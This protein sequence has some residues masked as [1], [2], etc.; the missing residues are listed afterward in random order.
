[1]TF[2]RALDDH[3][4]CFRKLADISEPVINAGNML[5]AALKKGGKLLICGNGGSA[6]DSQHFAAEVMGRFAKERRAWPAIALSTDTS[7]I[8]AVANDYSF[9]DIFARQVEG[10]GSSGDLLIGISTSGN[11]E[12]VVRA[13]EKARKKHIGIVALLGEKGGKLST[14]ADLAIHAP[15]T[16]T[17]RIQEIHAF[18]LHYWAEA[19]EN[20]LCDGKDPS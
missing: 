14:L 15:S 13:V 8:T 4:A 9:N 10:I 19:L 5:A 11:S 1:M 20:A 6:A 18:I 2:T 17:P 12:N 3:L 7:V 16:I